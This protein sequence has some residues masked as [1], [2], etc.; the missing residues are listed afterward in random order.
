[1][2]LVQSDTPMM[3][4]FNELKQAHPDCILFFRAGDFYEMF[5]EDAVKASEALNI[6]L[7]S[8]NRSSE[9]PIPMAGVPHH[10]FETYLNRLTSA[11]FKVAIA[12]QME[13]PALAK[14]VVRREVVRVVTPGTVTSDASLEG[15]RPHYL[16][17]VEPRGRNGSTGLAMADLSTGHFEALEFPE[18]QRSRL[19]EF[20]AVERPR[21]ILLPESREEG[22]GGKRG[23]EK[24]ERMAAELERCL[25][26]G[27][28]APVPV[29]RTPAAWFDL[30][31][32]KKRLTEQFETAS[33][34]GFGVEHMETAQR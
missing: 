33:L 15:D 30:A 9:H 4:Q 26:E 17:A 22:S 12:E 19:F 2:S 3:K 24:L 6:A 18:D 34:A 28:G 27:G 23:E 25:I 1:M 8:R 14:G 7:T 31:R 21:E 29:E 11:G 13:D 20:L 16:M 10:A 32:A 5:G